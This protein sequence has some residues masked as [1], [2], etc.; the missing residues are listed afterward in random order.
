M[1]NAVPRAE[2]AAA[3]E[4]LPRESWELAKRLLPDPHRDG[5]LE[6]V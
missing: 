5:S 4:E 6:K 3:R 2:L 1:A